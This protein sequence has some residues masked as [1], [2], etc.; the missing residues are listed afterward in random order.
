[1]FELIHGLIIGLFIG[2]PFGPIGA[3]YMRVTLKKGIRYGIMAGIGGTV[4]DATL[5]A[6]VIYGVSSI[7][8]FLIREHRIIQTICGIIAIILGIIMAV[9]HEKKKV[10]LIESDSK[11]KLLLS[12]FSFAVI[13][14]AT[15]ISLFI[16]TSTFSAGYLHTRVNNALMVLGIYLGSFIW[17]AVFVVG[18]N[19]LRKWLDTGKKNLLNKGIGILLIISG[20]FLLISK[21]I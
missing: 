17:M 1:M 10:F 13:N 16:I 3:I 20:V 19:F 12:T 4:A 5:G 6:I 14:P 15:V 11:I 18:A 2:M 9:T 7:S 21:N 8:H